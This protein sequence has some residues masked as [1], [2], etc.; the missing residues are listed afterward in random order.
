MRIRGATTEL[1]NEGLDI[2]GMAESTATLRQ[3]MQALSGVDIMKNNTTFKSTYQILDE[4]ADKWQNLTDIQQASVTE[5]VAGK[6]QGNIMSALMSNWDIAEDTM[7]QTMQA[8]GSADRE[9]ARQ[10]ESVQY[11]IDRFKAS[12]QELSNGFISSDFLKG[13]IDTGNVAVNVLDMLVSKLGI[14]NTAILGYSGFKLFSSGKPKGFSFRECATG[15]F[16]REVYEL[17]L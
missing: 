5:L 6:R 7:N 11:S 16:S 1:Q 13:F 2:E 15:Q 12:F 8:E 3:E 4:L 9:L 10:Q 14:V 17:C